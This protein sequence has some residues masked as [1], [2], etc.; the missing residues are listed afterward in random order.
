M[1]WGRSDDVIIAHRRVSL[2]LM[3]ECQ[4][5]AALAG[6]D[7]P[8]L[9]FLAAEGRLTPCPVMAMTELLLEMCYVGA[10]Q[11]GAGPCGDPALEITLVCLRELNVSSSFSFNEF[12]C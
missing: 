12:R 4:G 9:S 5:P 8:S 11:C 3:V 6:P 2:T 10:V 1:F 7:H